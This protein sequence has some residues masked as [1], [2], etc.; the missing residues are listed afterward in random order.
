MTIEKIHEIISIKQSK[1]LEKNISFDTQ[2]RNKAKNDFQK[3]FY[4]LLVNAAFGKIL[5]FI[6]NRLQLE[7][8]KKE[9]YKEIIKQQSKL[10]F[11]GIHKSYENCSTF[12]QKKFVMDEAIYIGLAI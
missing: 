11:I 1:W 8:I 9:E 12:R 3:D 4:K 6:R 5:D 2:K 7:F 10:T